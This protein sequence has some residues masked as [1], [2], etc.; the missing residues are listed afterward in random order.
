[1]WPRLCIALIYSTAVLAVP[2]E[3]RAA[4]PTVKIQNGTVIGST[5]AGVDS[6]KGIPF[7]EPPTGTRRL[8]PPQTVSAAFGTITATAAAPAC[9]QFVSQ[10]DTTDIP[11]D[12]LGELADTPLVQKV[13]NEN[14]DCLYINVQR[15]AGTTASD[16]LPVLFWIFGGGFE[17]GWAGM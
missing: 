1:M 12:V 7:A 3:D 13:L 4:A 14:E 15:P 16:K 8:K 6:F 2:I 10:V 11:S 5:L 17:V 9:P